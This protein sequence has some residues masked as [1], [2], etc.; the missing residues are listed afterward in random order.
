[1]GKGMVTLIRQREDL[2]HQMEGLGDFRWG[3]VSE[4]HRQCGKKNCA[5]A[6]KK[7]PGHVQ[8]L[9]TTR[10]QGKTVG[11]SLHLGPEL[12]QVQQQVEEGARFQKLCDDV[13][14]VNEAIC[15]SRPV[16][17]VEHEQELDALKKKLQRRFLM[18]RKKR[19]TV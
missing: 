9:W 1:M 13:W 6:D 18:R 2:F 16:P 14:E 5:C 15:R 4:T 7:H 12:D 17:Q 19:S 8:Y 11:R 3:S 10:K